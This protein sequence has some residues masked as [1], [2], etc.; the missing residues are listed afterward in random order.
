VVN[1]VGGTALGGRHLKGIQHAGGVQ[2]VLHGPADDAPTEHIEDDREIEEAGGG[3]DVRDVGDPQLIG[4]RRAEDP[5]NEIGGAG[6]LGDGPHGSHGSTALGDAA[7]AI[8]AQQARDPLLPD[9]IAG[10]PQ[11]FEETR[12]AV[13]RIRPR[14]RG[15]DRHADLR[16]PLRA[17]R[18]RPFAPRVKPT[19]RHAE[20]ATHR[21]HRQGG[22]IRTHEAEEAGG[23]VPDSRA[24]QAAAFPRMSRSTFNCRFSRR[25]RLS[26]SRS[27]VVST[28][29][30]SPRSA[31]AWKIQLRIVCS[32]GSNSFANSLDVRPARANA[33]I[34]SR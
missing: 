9:A 4:R 25:S 7:E 28:P 16:V 26:S 15:T 21:R 29:G 31:S 22:L 32:D 6:R 30:R 2:R 8:G 10:V 3:G 19:L 14:V 33:M 13:R 1:Y 27:S 20:H 23:I 11:I 24:N 18:R 12:R 5:L 17:T 34:C